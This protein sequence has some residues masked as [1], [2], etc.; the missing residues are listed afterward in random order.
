MIYRQLLS[1]ISTAFG[2]CLVLLILDYYLWHMYQG[3][4]ISYLQPYLLTYHRLLFVVRVS[5]ILLYYFLLYLALKTPRYRGPVNQQNEIPGTVQLT[6]FILFLISVVTFLLI[7]YIPFPDQY[8]YPVSFFSLLIFLPL[9]KFLF[10]SRHHHSISFKKRPKI[11]TPDSINIKTRGKGYIN[12]V[13][14]FRHTLVVAGSG[15]GKS[16]SIVRPFLNQFVQKDY[17]GIVYD[18]KFPT[19]TNELNTILVKSRSRK[20]LYILDF[21]NIMQCHRLNPVDP[22]YIKSVSYA[23]EIATNLLNNLDIS[24]VRNTG[25]FFIRSSINWL[26]SIIWFYKVKHPEY[27]TLPHIWNTVLYKDF[28]QVLSMLR[29][30]PV[31][32]DYIM[33]I[34][35]SLEIGAERQLAGQISTLRNLIAKL[36]SP[37]LNWILSG[38]DFSLDINDP[39]NPVF[40]SIG[41]NPQVRKSLAPVVSSILT[42]ALQQM[43]MHNK[44]KSFLLLDEGPSIYLDELDHISAV[45]RANRIALVYVMQDVSM[46]IE[47]Y[48]RDKTQSIISNMNNIFYGR[49]NIPE[50]ARLIS[51][52]IGKEE[53]EHISKSEGRRIDDEVNY[54][55]NQNYSI[56]EK[57]IVRPENIMNLKKGEFLGRTTDEGQQYFW[58]KIRKKDYR[59][60]Y[61]IEPFVDFQSNNSE[62]KD[63][64]YILKEN[65]KKIRK[66]VEGVIIQYNNIYS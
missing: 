15:S 38:S 25:E 7:D 28:K 35:S 62:I 42:V 18:Y 12:V 37:E 58:S 49:V 57:Y 26:T 54:N 60:F 47:R 64:E 17:C 53:R 50:T 44:H 59:Q 19:L 4:I 34:T 36:N 65:S 8:L 51:E 9:I 20:P 45:S 16:V 46:M 39:D 27:C 5:I 56:M 3:N 22:I 23:E 32:A 11:H 48:G 14:P 41:M 63:F 30:D 2:I 10:P 52:T 24:S 29:N 21:N 13:E 1:F 33:S 66:E 61:R 6:A 40:L 31:S 55:M 43:N